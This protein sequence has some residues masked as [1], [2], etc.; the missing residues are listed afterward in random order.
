MIAGIGY[1]LLNDSKLMNNSSV[2]MLD[3]DAVKEFVNL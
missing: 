3:S 2:M 1:H